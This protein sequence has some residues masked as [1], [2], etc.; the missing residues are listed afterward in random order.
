MKQTKKTTKV[1]TTSQ[2]EIDRMSEMSDEKNTKAAPKFPLAS[3]KVQ[4]KEGGY[5]KTVL[6]ATGE[7]EVGEDGKALLE[8]IEN[9]V[10][11]ILRPRKSFNFVGGDYQLF[12]SEGGNTAKSVFS[13][14]RKSETTKGFSIEMVTQG[15]PAEI[16]TQFP[17]LKM[18]QIIYFLLDTEDGQELV[19]LKVKGMSLG[20]I[21][22]YWKEFGPGEHLFQYKTILGEE[23]GKNQF[24]KFIMSTFKKGEKVKDFTEIKKAMELISGKIDEIDAYYKERDAEAQ[25]FLAGKAVDMGEEFGGEKGN[26]PPSSPLDNINRG[27]KEDFEGEDDPEDGFDPKAVKEARKGVQHDQDEID[28]DKIPFG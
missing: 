15:T 8:K 3:L 1:E 21:F 13:V 4:G 27:R 12:T 14:F 24:G 11:V 6:T 28:V 26:R 19:R 18:V 23:K 20:K 25:E 22:D 9:P 7:M 17:E 10:G 5:Y 16:K 2:E